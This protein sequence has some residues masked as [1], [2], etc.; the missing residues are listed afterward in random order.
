MFNIFSHQGNTNKEYCKILPHLVW[1]GYEVPPQKAKM[2]GAWSP[3]GGA[4]LESSGN[5]GR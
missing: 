5:F 3:T 1:F 2:L 4:T